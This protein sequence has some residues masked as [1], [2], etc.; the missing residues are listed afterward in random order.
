MKSSPET[1][2][3]HFREQSKNCSALGSP[4]TGRLLSLCAER[5]RETDAVATHVLNWPGDG[6]T[7]ADNVPLRLAGALHALVLEAQDTDLTAVYPPHQAADAALW[8]AVSA[9]LT[10]HETRLRDWLTRAPQTNEVRRAS[11]LVPALHM[12]ARATGLPLALREVGCSGGL[13]L[14]C[15]AFAVQAG[16]IAYGPPDATLRLSPDWDGPAPHPAH[17]QIE[18][19]AGTDLAPVRPETPAGQLTLKAYTWPD[20]TDRLE[21]IDIA[22]RIARTAPASIETADALDWM[23]SGAVDPRH[24]VATV[25]FHTVAWQYLPPVAKERGAALLAQLA[26]KATKDAPLAHISLEADGS[27]PGGALTLQ[28]WPD[29]GRLYQL[30]RVDFHGRWVRWTGPVAL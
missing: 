16:D 10:R 11:A 28:L 1:V 3:E 17:L 4:F 6:G 2:R 7:Y 20:Q 26:A 18:S 22:S 24:G 30:G 19:L 9:A 13:N 23:A 21:R 27:Q 8:A 5:L 14:R 12:V 29:D 25:L 15:A